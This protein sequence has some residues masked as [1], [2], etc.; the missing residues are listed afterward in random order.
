MY[1]MKH[2]T[3]ET[4]MQITEKEYPITLTIQELEQ[5]VQKP[6]YFNDLP[7]FNISYDFQGESH[8]DFSTGYMFIDVDEKRL[9]VGDIIKA[10]LN[11]GLDEKIIAIVVGK[12]NWNDNV[13]FYDVKILK[14]FIGDKYYNKPLYRGE[15]Y[16]LPC[17]QLKDVKR[18]LWNDEQL[19]V[20]SL[21]M[22]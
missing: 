8:F 4:N 22:C 19:R 14:H 15:I 20:I 3:M 7:L 10:E 5:S 2:K 1:K 12:T 11:C 6:E 17:H 9:A 16:T 21:S 13:N 18:V